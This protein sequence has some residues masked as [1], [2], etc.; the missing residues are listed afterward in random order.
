MTGDSAPGEDPLRQAVTAPR[1][2]GQPMATR[3]RPW[4]ARTCKP[5]IY[6][7]INRRDPE[8]AVSCQPRGGAEVAA[9]VQAGIAERGIAIDFRHAHC[10]NACMHGPNIRIIPSNTRFYGVRVA[11][12]AEVLDTVERHLAERPPRRRPG[13]P[14]DGSAAGSPGGDGGTG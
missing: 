9:A 2:L 8:V 3:L 5:A 14:P 12:V 10:L 13:M 7:C 11:D 4:P 6:V 1:D